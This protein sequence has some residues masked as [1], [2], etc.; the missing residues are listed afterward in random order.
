MTSNISPSNRHEWTKD[1]ILLLCV[2]FLFYFFCLWDYPLFTPDE[3]RYSE[4]AREMVA[5]GDYITPRVNGIAFLDKPIFHYWLQAIAIHSFGLKEWALRFFPML[6][7]ILGCLVTYVAGRNLFDRRTGLISAILLA[8]TP[9]YFG[10]AH[11]ANLDLEVAVFISSSL[12]FFI[13]S[14]KFHH[15]A[16]TY[17][18]IAAYICASFA[19][20]TKGLIG[21]FFPTTII[22][23]W[24]L[25]LNQ[26]YLLKQMKLFL[27]IC[28]FAV[29]V[30]PW[31]VLA[32]KANPQFFD[33]FFMTQHVTRFFS[34]GEFNNQTTFWFYAPVVLAGFFPWTVFL[35]QTFKETIRQIWQA[36]KERATELFLIL[37]V[38]IVFTFF[39]IPHSKIVS[40]I[41]PIFPALALLVGRYLATH[42]QSVTENTARQLCLLLS[43]L[44]L[45]I[46]L[47]LISL[48]F[49][50]WANLSPFF[51][52]YLNVIIV[53]FCLTAVAPL[54]ILKKNKLSLL[55]LVC[56]FCNI[57][58]LL[59]LVMGATHLN[60]NTAKPL[61]TYLKTIIKPEDKVISYFKYYYDVPLYL[62]RRI[63]IAANWQSPD[64]IKKD[65]W[66]REL[67]I[68]MPYQKTDDLL[69][70][71][72][73]F[74][75]YW[76]SEKRVFVFLND[77]YFDQFK[78]RA[79]QYF[80]LGKYND[81]IL[82]SNKPTITN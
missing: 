33:Y 8:T 76:Q 62:E 39:S 56:V 37:W 21:L 80:H 73:T 74:W 48:S 67:W 25:L 32:Q 18:L 9:L 58:F 41:L 35:Y 7:G 78:L 2:F 47:L 40:Y 69:I 52:P 65:N 59:T 24:I 19:C 75:Q 29:I 53:I 30:V 70:N 17:F 15:K 81:I 10:S 11:Y 66:V 54:F 50:P 36:P 43:I 82:L 79:T 12:L 28:L 14:W 34:A 71:E 51:K 1:L 42:W 26:W 45:L 16:R 60:Q 68:S 20:L 44:S 6:L 31:Y 5:T 57:F 49:Y 61:V 22:G 46:S 13:T 64:I 4:V 23:L 38:F 55:F 27:G 3:G 63:L 77:N 72:E